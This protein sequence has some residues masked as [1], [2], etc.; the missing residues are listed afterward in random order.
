MDQ[1]STGNC[2]NH[3]VRFMYMKFNIAA[4]AFIAG[5]VPAK[6]RGVS[7]FPIFVFYSFMGLLVL[8]V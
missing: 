3:L 2:C 4:K 5:N 6:K 1:A 8:Y 7:L